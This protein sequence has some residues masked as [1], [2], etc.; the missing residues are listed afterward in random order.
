MD[1]SDRA[2]REEKI[3]SFWKEKNIFKK[4]LEKK[5]PKREFVFYE[6]PPTANGRPG[7]HHVEARSFKDAIPRY[8]T[9]QGYHVRRKA[10]WDTHGLPV[11]LE[12]EKQ[13]GLKSK[14]EIE[15]Y[16]V[17][18]FNEECKQNVWKYV[19]EWQKFTDRVGYWVDLDNAYVTYHNSYIESVW[20]VLS[21]VNDRGLLYKDYKVVPWCPRCGTGLSSHELAQGY[22]DVKDLSVYT[23]FKVVGEENTYFL[24]WTTTPWTLPG[25]VALAVGEKID[26]VEIK[27][28]EDQRANL[29]LAKDRLEIVEGDY[30]IVREMKGSDLVGLEY[31]SLY[32][33][34]KESY[35]GEGIEKAYKV[36]AADFVNTEDGTGIVHTAVMYGQDDFVLGTELGLPKHHLVDETG[37]FKPE[38]GFLASKFVKDEETAVDIIKD[39]AHR[40]LLFKKEKYEHSY[41]FCW[42]CKTPLIYYARDSW[43]IRMSDLRDGLVSENKKI[44]WE[45]DHIKE[46]RFGEWL[47]EVKDWALSRERYWGTPLPVWLNSD[48]SKK[49]VVDSIEMLKKHAKTSGNKYFVMRHGEAQNNVDRL[50]SAANLNIH[51]LSQLG[52]EQVRES[53]EKLKKE[54][55]DLV[56]TSPFMRTKETAK[57]AAEIFGLPEGSVIVDERLREFDAG[58][59]EGKNEDELHAYF[60]SNNLFLGKCPGGESFT[61]AKKRLGEALEDL[62]KTYHGK[63]ILIVTHKV[64]GWLLVAAAKR[65]NGVEAEELDVYINNGQVIELE[66]PVLPHNADFELDLHKPYIDEVVLEKDGEEYRRAKEVMDVWLDSGC[67]PFAQDAPERK[68]TGDF[69]KILYPADYISEAIDQTRGW[70]YTLHAVGVLMERGAAYKNVISLGHILDQEG[71]KMSK[72]VGNVVNPWEMIDKYGVDALRLW[73]Y[74]VNQPGESKNFDERTVDELNKRIFNLLDNVYSFYELYKDSNLEAKN[75]RPQSTHILDKWILAR[76]DELV[77]LT[78]SKLDN[79]K[80]LEP[81]RAMR[82]FIDDLSTWYLRRSRDRLK[83]GDKD[84]QETLHYMMK[85][86]AKLLAPFAPFYADDLYQ[87]LRTNND[88]ES[89]HLEVWPSAKRSFFAL[90]PLFGDSDSTQKLRSAPVLE[91]MNKVRIIVSQALDERQ[92]ANIKVRQPLQKLA[93]KSLQLT[94]EYLELIKDEVN[95]KEVVEDPNLD[96][97]VELDT[98]ITSELEEEGLVREEIRN[99][100]DLRKEKN[101]KPGDKMEYEVPADKKELFAKYAEEIKKAT[102]IEF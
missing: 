25:N 18:K 65:L 1:K 84:A 3:L 2:Q 78:T 50:V 79:Y 82:E 92:K 95:V 93:V 21:H 40:G 91:K 22:Q 51:P 31:E 38:T 75:S 14:R 46:G 74:S 12:V 16:G 52:R 58:D 97:E 27:H 98:N 19:D 41:P 66:T 83:D 23:K 35:K 11:E 29:V 77:S 56:I 45:P 13:L 48:N 43:Y 10:G 71:K 30:E 17:A 47:R 85:N 49:L 94:D 44:N 73:M 90:S 34:L 8:K 96:K 87:K 89:V 102:N 39:L 68:K 33:F 70:F 67:M 53:S 99:I 69:S 76:L 26:Y 7:I 24:A 61:D 4:T 5:S 100:Q 54:K 15:E 32:P 20:S 60:D 72:S 55:I 28:G 62:E 86:L 64:C 36:Y 81:V 101:L 9:M 42:R 59:F 6:G 37:H 63:N 88:P 80:L 57:L